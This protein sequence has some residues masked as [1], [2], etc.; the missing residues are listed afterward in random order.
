LA[1][2]LTEKE[3]ELEFF[4]QLMVQVMKEIGKMARKKEK[5]G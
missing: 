3:M 4:N 1:I 2:L 5:A